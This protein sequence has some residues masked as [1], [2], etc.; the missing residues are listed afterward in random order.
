M[1]TAREANPAHLHPLFRERHAALSAYV[2]ESKLPI[3]PFELWRD[4]NR[5]AFLFA[6]GRVPG[7]GQ[8]GHHVTFEQAWESTHQYGMAADWV[9][10]FNGAWSWAPPAGH[11]WDE[12]HALAAKAGLVWLS[13]EQPH[14]QAPNFSAR[15]ILAGKAPWPAGG[16]D[17]WEQNIEQ[18][19]VA[20]GREPKLASGI[21]QPGAPSL[22]IARPAIPGPPVGMA[23]DRVRGLI[24]PRD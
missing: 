8:A 23:F 2:A 13:F 11:S 5:Q 4:P 3:E 22:P 24:V 21:R 10:W 20:W 9:W 7:I 17:T 6:E 18:A 1:S 19:I 16:D 14:V 15:D 12:F